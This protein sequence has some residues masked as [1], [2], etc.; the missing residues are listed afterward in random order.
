MVILVMDVEKNTA[1]TETGK[2]HQFS[3]YK[4]APTGLLESFFCV[5]LHSFTV[6]NSIY[7][8]YNYFVIGIA[9]F[10]IIWKALVQVIQLF[11][12]FV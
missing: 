6:S 4:L 2:K 10:H 1:K 12:I 7:L 11:Y 8:I 3:L 5:V 9:D